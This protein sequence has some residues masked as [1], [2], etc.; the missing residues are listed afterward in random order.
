MLLSL[1]IPC[2]NEEESI[3]ELL[4][5]LDESLK[6][7]EGLGHTV[8]VLLVDDGSRDRTAQ[9]LRE[10][11]AGRPQ[12]RVIRFARNF[13]QTAAMAAGFDAA[14]GE[15]VVPIDADLQN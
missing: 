13:G 15:V 10:A 4:P 3:P 14:R 8:E 9:L 6:T 1:V 5:K 7:L 2:Y 12:L 11:T